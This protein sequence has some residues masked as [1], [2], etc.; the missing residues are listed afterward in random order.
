MREGQGETSDTMWAA[1]GCTGV[2]VFARACVYS[3]G[4]VRIRTRARARAGVQGRA[5]LSAGAR[6]SVA[7]GE[8]PCD[9]K[10]R[11]ELARRDCLVR[12]R[13][14]PRTAAQSA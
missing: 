13:A 8:Q 1:A 5:G 2:C 4:R 7:G 3:H 6:L 10:P 12:L 14:T 11:V 9:R